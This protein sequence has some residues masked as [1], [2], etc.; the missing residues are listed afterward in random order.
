MQIGERN[1]EQG[2]RPAANRGR[3][4]DLFIEDYSGKRVSFLASFGTGYCAT[5]IC[6]ASRV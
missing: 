4:P 6:I 1:T 3:R 5:F 2:A